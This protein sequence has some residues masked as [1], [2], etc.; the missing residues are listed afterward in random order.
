MRTTLKI[1][2]AL[3]AAAGLYALWCAGGRE[4]PAVT[5]NIGPLAASSVG[6]PSARGSL[7]GIQPVMT[8]QDYATPALFARKL[9]AA[10]A[11]ARDSGCLTPRSVVVFPEYIG[12]WL[13][14][15]GEKRSLYDRATINAAM[16][17]LV[18]SN[19]LRFVRAFL[20]APKVADKLTDSLFRMQAARMAA[21]YHDTFAGLARRYAVAIVAGSIVLPDP[22]IAD[23]RLTPRRGAPLYN[24]SVVYRPDGSP[25]PQIVRK[26]F[27]IAGELPF[28]A[29]AAPEAL[30]VFDLPPG[31]TGVL[32]CA[33]AWYPQPYRTLRAKGAAILL[34]P[35]F[36]TGVGGMQR[37]WPG[38]DGAPPPADVDP[39]DVGRLTERQAWLKY[40]LP[41]R[42]AASGAR[43]G[44]NLFLRGV[45]WEIHADGE[46]ILVH[47]GRLLEGPPAPGGSII[48]LWL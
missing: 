27:P 12:T 4:P 2:I 25:H 18:L 44:L 15:V 1:L 23:G 42:I 43:Y 36:F 33:D 45:F 11:Q 21:V 35:S 10:L 24:A 31:P 40:A 14:A 13:V 22:F 8:P 20:A 37:P 39:A 38:Y 47:E 30:P 46:P 32:I 3:L 7:V 26:V 16:R 6:T 34:V 29:A 48:A 17:T 41:G 28:T 9:D 19:P 5:G